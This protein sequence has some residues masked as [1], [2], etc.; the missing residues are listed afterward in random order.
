[1]RPARSVTLAPLVPLRTAS[2]D[3]VQVTPPSE[4]VKY[5]SSPTPIVVRVR[6]AG[7][8]TAVWEVMVQAVQF[9]LAPPVEPP[10]LEPPL[11]LPELLSQPDM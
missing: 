7:T 8:V 3:T 2:P 4:Q 11:G 9:C 10:G 5:T 1:L 6:S